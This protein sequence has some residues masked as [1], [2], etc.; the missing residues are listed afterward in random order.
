MQALLDEK[1]YQSIAEKVK[2]ML[3]KDYDLVPKRKPNKLIGMDEFREKYGHGKA[4]AWLKLYLLP[5]MPGV[6]GLNAG[7]GH[8]IKIDETK[9]ERWL[10]KHEEEVDWNKSLP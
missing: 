7:R 5:Q 1:D 6:F 4:P 2:T 8:P 3:L 10:A 9:A